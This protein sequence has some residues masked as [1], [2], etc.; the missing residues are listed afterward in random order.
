MGVVLFFLIMFSLISSF[1]LA[2]GFVFCFALGIICP[3]V[4]FGTRLIIS[5]LI[6]SFASSM[7]F[8]IAKLA[9]KEL[10]DQA[11]EVKKMIGKKLVKGRSH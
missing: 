10:D 2:T 8:S 9:L 4:D 1:L 11:L 7:A 6:S 5:V 3:E